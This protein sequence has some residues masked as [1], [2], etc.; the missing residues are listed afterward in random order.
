MKNKV[1]LILMIL[2]HFGLLHAQEKNILVEDNF[3]DNSY[4]WWVG[5]S[6]VGKCEI[7]HGE[8]LIT[9]NGEKSWSSN[10]ETDINSVQDFVIETKLSRIS[11]T[12]ENG[13]GLTW[14]KSKDGYYNFII[15]PKG[16]YYVRKVERG[17]KG[18]YLV[19]WK[20]TTYINSNPASN[21]LKIQKS[22]KDLMF[23]INDKQVEKITFQPFFGN[24]VG[25][26]IYQKQQVACEYLLVYGSGNNLVTIQQNLPAAPDL[27]ILQIAIK[28]N[29]DIENMSASYGNGNSII[30]PGESIEVTA[31][32]QNF[33]AVAAKNVEAKVQLDLNDRNISFPDEFKTFDLGD[34][35]SGDYKKLEFF[36]F[37]SRKYTADDIPFKAILREKNGSYKKEQPLGLKMNERTTN[38]VDVNI[39]KI[40]VK[41]DTEMKQ[42]QEV[43]ELAD[44]DKNIPVTKY[45]GNNTLAVIIGIEEY[46]YAPLVDFAKRDAQVF[47]KYASSVFGIPKENIYFLS[48]TEATLGE[49]NKIFSKDGWLARR[50]TKD[51][52]NI[53]VYYAGHGAP[54]V[55]TQS[56]YLIPYDIDP[57]YART[58][59]SI[60]DLYSSLSSLQAKSV[61]VFLDACF[62]G[63]S[64]NEKMLIADA[65]SVI[66]KTENSAFSAKNMAVI[67]AASNEEYSASYPEK[68]HGIFTYYLLK[69]L[70]NNSSALDKLS[71]NDFFNGIKAD[72]SKRAGYLD[73]EQTPSLV[74]NDK[75]R[76]LII[77]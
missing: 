17:K 36:F 7:V 3:S 73:K 57:N 11:G 77:N 34:I 60:N 12:D 45:N 14:G 51:Q 66:I 18:Q 44:V 58:G 39:N 47:Y 54:D 59:F 65:R 13:Y 27:R 26:M 5:R 67:S 48:N 4:K 25:F 64:R 1:T 41:K 69:S 53:I 55:K 42:I 33:G 74:G 19:D 2:L 24:Q 21:K 50:T 52:S 75:D 46:K 20:K 31:F 32:V 16:K 6:P 22:G 63:K 71:I 56:A 8:Y 76:P 37:T 9:Y 68:Y 29:Q 28:D 70:Q 40:D 43:I 15:T 61:T 10:I 62:S 30:E 49:F 23:F 35:E 38:V 72:V